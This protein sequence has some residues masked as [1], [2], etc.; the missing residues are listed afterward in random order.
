MTKIETLNPDGLAA[1][2]AHYSLVTR[3]DDRLY[4]A[5]LVS[6]DA[7]GNLL[8]KGSPREQAANTCR[9]LEEICRQHGVDLGRVVHCTQYI[10]DIA[11][12]QDANA[13]YA[14]VF[15]EHRPARATVIVDLIHVD[16]LYE[17]VAIVEL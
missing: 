4:T 5:G 9:S 16:F 14:E 3:T 12:Y 11:H 10:T 6:L 1:P 17:L 13:G 7:D 8:G 2:A 15:G